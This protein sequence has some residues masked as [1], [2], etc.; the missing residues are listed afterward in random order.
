M[1]LEIKPLTPELTDDFINFFDHRAFADRKGAFCYCT[2]FHYDCSLDEHYKPGRDSMR[3]TAINYI[4]NRLLKGYLAYDG[5]IAVGWCNADRKE[6]YIRLMNDHFLCTGNVEKTKSVVCFEIAP[7]Y[8]G[9]GI[10]TAFLARIC[11]DAKEEGYTFVEGYPVLHE[12]NTP[13]D[14]AG[15]F[16][17]YEKFGFIKVAEQGNVVIMRKELI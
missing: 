16:H 9:K 3:N 5:D 14:Y 6:N 17:L 1:N 11:D 7:K 8:R 4:N 2:W 15:P 10:A 12:K 13:L